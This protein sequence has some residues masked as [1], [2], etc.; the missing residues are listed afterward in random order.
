MSIYKRGQNRP[1]QMTF[2]LRST[3]EIEGLTGAD[4]EMTEH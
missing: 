4:P 1:A 2:P 3:I